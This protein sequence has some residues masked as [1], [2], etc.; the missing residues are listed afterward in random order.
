MSPMDLRRLLGKLQSK[1]L[2]SAYSKL[3]RTDFS[4]QR[5]W[6]SASK[7]NLHHNRGG[8]SQHKGLRKVGVK[9]STPAF[10]PFEVQTS[11][12]SISWELKMPQGQELKM[13]CSEL[14]FRHHFPGIPGDRGALFGG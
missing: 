9:R 10:I 11:E 3:C 14:I 12:T 1:L 2:Y 6:T 5:P 8:I 4:V 13:V 7:T